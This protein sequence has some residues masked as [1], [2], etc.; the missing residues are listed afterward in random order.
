MNPT[1]IPF[2]TDAALAAAVAARWVD[3]IESARRLGIPHRVALPGGR[4]TRK[5]L[6]EAAV[7]AARR[8]VSMDGVDFH[9]GDE[10][11]VPP[12]DAESNFRL[13]KET[14]FDA[15]R[16]PAGR[17]HR[18]RG[19]VDPAEAAREAE[20][21]LRA[22]CGAKPGE[23][24]VLDLVFLGMGEDAHVASLFPGA[25][26]AVTESRSTYLPVIGPK[27]P[28]QRVSLSFAALAAAREIWVLASGTGKEEALKVSLSGGG[29][30]LGRV[31]REC[32]KPMVFT[33]IRI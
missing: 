20:A 5:F 7:E 24:P 19:E 14:L 33:D 12:D 9:W 21:A 25:P 23:Q 22:E 3:R 30:P 16:V 10:R 13:A 15:A 26:A 32:G 8:G 28:P 18:I 2:P 1:V 29:T 31:L 4:I 11:C 6:S 27:P 17:I